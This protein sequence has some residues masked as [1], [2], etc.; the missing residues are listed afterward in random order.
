M[1]SEKQMTSNIIFPFLIALIGSIGLCAGFFLPYVSNTSDDIDSIRA[2]YGEDVIEEVG[3]TVDEFVDLSIFDFTKIYKSIDKDIGTV[4]AVIPW[5]ICGVSILI[6]LF[7][8]MRKPILIL[9]FDVIISFLL[10]VFF[11]GWGRRFV[12]NDIYISAVS[13]YLYPACVVIVAVGA[14]WMLVVK[15]KRKRQRKLEKTI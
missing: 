3:L 12:E 15:I 10:Y 7:V 1:N 5:T 9:F 6:M 14:I 4:Y 8:L 11:D 2:Y 13:Y